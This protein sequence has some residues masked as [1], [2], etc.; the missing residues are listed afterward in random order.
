MYAQESKI[1][2]YLSS[3]LNQFNKLISDLNLLKNLKY[4]G[5]DQTSKDKF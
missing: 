5:L 1:N 3:G 4:Y 2:Q